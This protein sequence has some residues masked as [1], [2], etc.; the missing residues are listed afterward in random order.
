M[1][2]K[3]EQKQRHEFTHEAIFRIPHVTDLTEPEG[4]NTQNTNEFVMSQL[5]FRL[6]GFEMLE[7]EGSLTQATLNHA[8]ASPPFA[9]MKVVQSMRVL[10][11]VK[12]WERSRHIITKGLGDGENPLSII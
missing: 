4:F 7:I 12:R 3:E 11:L 10:Q 2:G 5:R 9:H 6:K 8:L 1:N